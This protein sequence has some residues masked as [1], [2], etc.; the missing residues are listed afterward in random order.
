[1]HYRQALFSVLVLFVVMAGF[2]IAPSAPDAVAREESL[3]PAGALDAAAA[4][5]LMERLGDRLT[6]LDVRN[7]AEFQEGHIPGA[8]HLP[9]QEPARRM[10]AVPE[11]RPVLIVCR[12]GRRATAAYDMLHAAR[13]GSARL[14]YLRGTPRYDSDGT[15]VFQ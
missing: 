11:D 4:R 15:F 1:M 3:P 6:V 2:G 8:L 7:P 5:Q 12:T 9:L 14:W 10:D 13:P